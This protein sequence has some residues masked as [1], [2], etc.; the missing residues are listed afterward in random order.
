MLLCSCLLTPVKIHSS[1]SLKWVDSFLLFSVKNINAIKRRRLASLC[2]RLQLFHDAVGGCW[3]R[4]NHEARSSEPKPSVFAQRA[5]KRV[6]FEACTF[7]QVHFREH[8]A[9][10]AH[11]QGFSYIQHSTCM[12]LCPSLACLSV[13]QLL[14][15]AINMELTHLGLCLLILLHPYTRG[16]VPTS[17]ETIRAYPFQSPNSNGKGKKEKKGEGKNYLNDKVW[18]RIKCWWKFES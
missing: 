3:D 6:A 1:T 9:C 8:R 15:S 17:L 13:Q 12:W 2:Q 11:P 18:L 7:A 5:A 16:K 10:N 14:T 4:Q